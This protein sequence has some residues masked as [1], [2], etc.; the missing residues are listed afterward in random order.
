MNLTGLSLIMFPSPIEEKNRLDCINKV[1]EISADFG[2]VFDGDG[3]RVFMID[4]KGRTLTG[5]IITAM[6]AENILKNN[7]GATILYN[8]IVGR[9]VP[10]IVKKWG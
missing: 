4:E 10:E 9:V 6:I 5:T 2:L 7:P 1:K 3:D 8:A